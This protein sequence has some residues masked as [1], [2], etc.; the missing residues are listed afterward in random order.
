MQGS[1]TFEDMETHELV[2]AIIDECL[3]RPDND[4]VLLKYDPQNKQ[5]III[6]PQG[7]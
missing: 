3:L 6:Y 1:F 4:S 2:E 5:R 7:I